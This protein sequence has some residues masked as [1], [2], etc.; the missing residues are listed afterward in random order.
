MARMI[1]YFDSHCYATC[2]YDDGVIIH[3]EDC[4]YNPFPNRK[5][6]ADRRIRD[7]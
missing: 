7:D 5:V 4:E 6:P 2:M 3:C 1:C